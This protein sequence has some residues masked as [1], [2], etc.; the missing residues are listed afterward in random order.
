MSK[1]ALVF[2]KVVEQGDSPFLD[3]KREGPWELSNID[4]KGISLIIWEKIIQ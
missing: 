3:K 4:N 1:D 2:D